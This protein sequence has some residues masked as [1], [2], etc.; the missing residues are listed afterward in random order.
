MESR[1]FYA[2]FWLVWL[3]V[4]CSVAASQ[5]AAIAASSPASATAPVIRFTLDFPASDPTHY[6]ISI[7]SD[8]RGSYSSR[9]RAENAGSTTDQ[10]PSHDPAE[11]G[12]ANHGS[13]DHDAAGHDGADGDATESYETDFVAASATASQMFELAKQA[14][15]F[16]GKVDSGNKHLAFTGAKTIRYDAPGQSTE[17]SY[18]YSSVSAVTNLTVIFQDMSGALEF[19]RRLEHDFRFQK[20]ALDDVLKQLEQEV[21]EGHLKQTFVIAPILQK[22]ADDPATINVSRAR[23]Q[24]ILA[25]ASAGK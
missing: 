18:N 23:A 5:Q 22:I 9:F 4:G 1:K 6:E 24:K 10:A 11:Q 19:G 3:A 12:S 13:T 16:S 2:G 7:S 21:N 15:Y 17:A 8:G 20:L 14:H 25:K